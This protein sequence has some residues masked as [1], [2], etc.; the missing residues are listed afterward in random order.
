M[1]A[2]S[3]FHCQYVVG[4]RVDFYVIGFPQ[5]QEKSSQKT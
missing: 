5:F 1:V 2:S 4:D 3:E